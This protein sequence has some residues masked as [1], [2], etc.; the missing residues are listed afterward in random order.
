MKMEV[1]GM[2]AAGVQLMGLAMFGVT[3]ADWPQYQHDARHSGFTTEEVHPPYKVAWKHCFLPD[4]VARR[5]QA[6]IYAHRVFVGTQHGDVYCFDADTGEALW[7]YEAAGSIQ[8]SAGCADGIVFFGSLDGCVYALDCRSGE[9][10]WNTQTDGPFTVAPL[11]AEGKVLMGNHRG[12]FL[13][14]DQKTGEVEWQHEIDAPI[15]NTAA[16]DAGKVLF[17][18]EDV[19]VYALDAETGEQL[20]VSDQLWGMSMK[21]Y[22]PVVHRGRVIV[23]PMASFEAEIYTGIHGRYGS[24]PNALPGGWWPV[25][26]AGK[27]RKGFEER[28]EEA[29]EERAGKMP[30]K[31]LEAQEAVIRHYEE[32]PED[33][34]MFVL[35]AD[36]GEIALIP[37][38]FRVQAMHG[39]VTPPVEDIDGYLIVP[40]VHINHCWARYDIEENRLVEFMI[41]P[42]PTN[43]DENLNVSCGGRYVFI[44]HCQEGN[45]N[46]T[47]VYD[48]RERT[49]NSVNVP[50]DN[51]TW[52]D[53]IQSGANPVSIAY[54]KFLHIL[55]DTLIVKEG[56]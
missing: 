56:E 8:H 37:P 19:K 52:Y 38:H 24:W 54:G 2:I 55:F 17:G 23:R 43:A 7:K 28:Y 31:L 49:W 26:G 36:T 10:V 51:V 20:W 45:A 22:C 33:Q 50:G 6:I 14:L 18:G 30:V 44:F 12:T 46:Y 48:L 40:W 4:R 34:D 13:A 27:W 16:Y 5:V 1:W 32:M 3:D 47:G 29:L 35:D 53:N 41:P 25:W 15:L 39:P 9:R 42:R 11:L 21:D